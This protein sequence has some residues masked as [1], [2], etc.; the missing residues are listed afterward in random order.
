MTSRLLAIFVA[1]VVAAPGLAAGQGR[2]ARLSADL[3]DEIRA[4][5]RSTVEVIVDGDDATINRVLTRHPLTLK[6]RLRRGAV[7]EVPAGQ[8]NRLADDP[9]VRAVAANAVVTSHM[10]LTTATTGADAALAGLVGSLGS[11]SGA[12]VGVAI[13]DSGISAHK[14]LSGKVVASVDF[15]RDGNRG[16]NQPMPFLLFIT[17]CV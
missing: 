6:K 4:G 16:R 12:G 1:F 15:T 9:D 8:L 13:I 2:R 3:N 7:L 10:A 5:N 14:S 11:V 17:Y